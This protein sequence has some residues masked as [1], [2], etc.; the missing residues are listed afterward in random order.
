MFVLRFVDPLNNI[1]IK[2]GQKIVVIGFSNY[3]YGFFQVAFKD[4]GLE[5]PQQFFESTLSAIEN[6]DGFGI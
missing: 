6:D 3:K 5:I 4:L 1:K 2:K